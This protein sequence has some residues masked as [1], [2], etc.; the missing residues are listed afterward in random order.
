MRILLSIF[1]GLGN[2][3]LKSMQRILIMLFF[4]PQ[5]IPGT[6]QV[7]GEGG[8]GCGISGQHQIQ[9]QIGIDRLEKMFPDFVFDIRYATTNN[10]RRRRFYTSARAL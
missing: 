2:S 7:W 4:S 10:F 8:A 5:G 9:P 3:S 1:H 6:I